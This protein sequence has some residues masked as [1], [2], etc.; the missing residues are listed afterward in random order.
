MATNNYRSNGGGNFAGNK[1]ENQAFASPDESRAVLAKY[2][3]EVSK[4]Q[5]QVIPTA[6]NNWRFAPINAQ[7]PLSI[8]F[9]T[10]N[11]EKAA[12]FVQARAQYPMKQI[13]S[14]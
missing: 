14:F 5:G 7:S 3:A 13:N 1:P 9:E 4:S 8:T 6:D 12:K 2:I 11:S 10:A